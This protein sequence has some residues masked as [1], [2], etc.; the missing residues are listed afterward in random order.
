MGTPGPTS[1]DKPSDATRSDSAIW[2]LVV[3]ALATFMLMLDLTVVNVALP[4]IRADFDSSFSA[5]QWILDAYA[6]GLAA[7]LLAAGSL[8]DRLGRKR[9]FDVG[10]V[11]FVLASLACGIAPNDTVLIIARLVQG[12]GGAILFAVGPALLGHEFRGKDRGVAFGVFGAVVGLA[13]AF[14]P[15]IG[16][17]LTETLGWRWIFLI[18]VPVTI[19][20][21]VIGFLKMRES[22]ADTPP[23]VDWSGMVTFSLALFFL[24]Y[25]FMGGHS[26]GWGSAQIV[27]SF[28]LSVVL[29]AVFAWLQ[30]SRPG[31]AMF[32]LTLFRNR[33]FNGLSV[34]TALC[35]LSVMPAL[36]L[37]IAYMQNMLGFEAFATGV[38]F[39]PLTLL[40]FV[41]AAIA[42]SMVAKLAP[43]I[44]VGA[45]QLLIAAGLFAVLFIEV[46]SA[47]TALIPAMILIGLGMG[48][49]NPPRAAF[50]IAV[51]TPDKAGMAS[52]V[53]ETFQQAGLAIGI[54][55]VGAF[56]Q[57][58]VEDNFADSEI[59]AQL[60]DSAG[61][62]GAAVSA[63]GPGVA[64]GAVPEGVAEQVR[65]A[66]ES[67]F[68]SGL[69][70]A[71]VLVGVLAA[72]SGVIAF[73]TMRKGD[74]DEAALATPG[75]PTDDAEPAKVS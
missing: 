41:A 34:V 9:V 70:S 55:A 69:E 17:G 57:G 30:I 22:R 60:G 5:L 72:I 18:N 11:V 66:A 4:D 23:P 36:F 51:T 59:A 31:R 21:I 53:N 10:L 6:L 46:D 15:L 42:G 73:V 54:A 38:R 32:D 26:E 20:A 1:L 68:V 47:W 16:G 24:V 14:G 52:G 67:A 63:G 48:V 29:L 45:S 49:F 19:A 2:T 75:V 35:A 58:R 65:A 37:L 43:S 12:L 40:L 28:V 61:E 50:S 3:V 39:L 33:T 74:L 27:G 25:G 71:M 8:A 56:F 44:L 13:I 7:V 64:A 62:V